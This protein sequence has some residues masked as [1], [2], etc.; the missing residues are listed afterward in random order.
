MGMAFFA[1]ALILLTLFLFLQC[2]AWLMAMAISMAPPHWH[3]TMMITNF[4]V[5]RNDFTKSSS[6]KQSR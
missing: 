6:L 1:P 4:T 3:G 2:A 5:F